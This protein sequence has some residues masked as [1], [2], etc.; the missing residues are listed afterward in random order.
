VLHETP[1]KADRGPRRGE[2]SDGTCLATAAIHD[3]GVEFD[4]P[5]LR[6][7]APAPSIE[8][9]VFLEHSSGLLDGIDSSSAGREDNGSGAERIAEAFACPRFMLRVVMS[10][11]F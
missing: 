8:T 10:D 4:D 6:Q 5:L 7:D 11:A 9:G 3:G 2:A 1:C